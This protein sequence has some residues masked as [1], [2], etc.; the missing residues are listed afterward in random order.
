VI[1]LY[2]KTPKATFKNQHIEFNPKYIDSHYKKEEKSGR[3]FRTVS[4]LQKGKGPARKFDDKLLEPP[5][6]MHW[7]WS[8]ERIDEAFSKGLIRFTSNGRPEKIQYLDEM[9]GD[10]IDDI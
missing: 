10:I 3:L 6:G 5:G 9:E 8:Q 4:L 1:F 7:I 2:S